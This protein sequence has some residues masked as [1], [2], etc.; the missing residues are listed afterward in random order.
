MKSQGG[1]AHRLPSKSIPLVLST[2]DNQSQDLW[3]RGPGMRPARSQV[4]INN[5]FRYTSLWLHC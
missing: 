3:G 1:A 2:L 5:L 4:E